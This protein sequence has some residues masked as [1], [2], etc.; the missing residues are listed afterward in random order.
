[1]KK[2]IDLFFKILFL[3]MLFL[4]IAACGQQQ[5]KPPILTEEPVVNACSIYETRNWHAWLDKYNVVE[6]KYRLNI[7]GQVDLPSAGYEITWKMGIAD[8]AHPPGQRVILTA[9]KNEHAMSVQVITPTE[10][11]FKQ[12]VPYS[13]YRNIMIYCGDRLLVSLSDVQLND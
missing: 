8:R 2:G 10:V 6:G 5:V 4:T 9:I 13:A 3:A 7:S 12:E 1:M 11:A